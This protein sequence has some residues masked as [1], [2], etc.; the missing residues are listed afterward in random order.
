MWVFD[1]MGQKMG[2]R[3]CFFWATGTRNRGQRHLLDFGP[4]RVS[5][6][7]RRSGNVFW[8]GGN[9]IIDGLRRKGVISDQLLAV[10]RQVRNIALD[11]QLDASVFR[12]LQRRTFLDVPCNVKF[13]TTLSTKFTDRQHRG[14]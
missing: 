6:D 7:G 3:P 10:V 2:Q 8:R 12:A 11:V 4:P 5:D 1:A 9:P 14:T 13:P